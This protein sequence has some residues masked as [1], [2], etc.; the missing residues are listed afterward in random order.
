MKIDVKKSEK[1]LYNPKKE[2]SI[3]NVPPM[4]YIVVKG[5]GNPNE[6]EG[7]Y[8]KALEKLYIVAF[9]IK[10]DK[11]Q[12]FDYVV[13]HLEGFWY[14]EGVVG[15]DNSNKE[16]FCWYSVIRLP[17]EI[18][19]EE[20]NSY[21]NICEKKKNLDFANVKLVKVDEGLCVQIM[22]LGSFDDEPATVALMDEYLKQNRYANDMNSQRLHH[23]IYLSDARKVVPEKWKT[24]IRHPIRKI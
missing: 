19:Q 8:K 12:V 24:V 3:I 17:I 22:H 11:K 20:F 5:K 2:P 21:L 9:T 14:Q 4:W 23:E 1:E 13:P 6:E 18:T 15:V 7:E 10:M 16:S